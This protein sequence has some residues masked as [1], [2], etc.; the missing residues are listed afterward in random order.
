MKKFRDFYV[1]DF[2]LAFSFKKV[3]CLKG[4]ELMFSLFKVQ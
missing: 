2:V 1:I 3:W 4:K